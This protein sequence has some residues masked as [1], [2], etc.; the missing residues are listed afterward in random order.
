M[1]QSYWDLCPPR[2]DFYK[3]RN[4][5]YFQGI[6]QPSVTYCRFLSSPHLTKEYSEK[7]KKIGYLYQ[8]GMMLA[9]IVLVKTVFTIVHN[10]KYIPVRKVSFFRGTNI[11][12][13]KTENYYK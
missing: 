3:R 1:H 8:F 11:H 9:Q 6:P 10:L 2:I 7:K 5:R 13:L 4:A 12:F